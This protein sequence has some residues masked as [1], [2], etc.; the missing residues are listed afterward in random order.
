MLISKT[1]PCFLYFAIHICTIECDPS[2]HSH[3]QSKGQKLHREREEDGSFSPSDYHHY[4]EGKH[5][6]EFDHEAI[7]GNRR[8][9]EE[10]DHLSPK[11]SQTRLSVLVNKMDRDQDGL[12]DKKELT[13]WIQRSFKM[14]TEEEGQ[15]RMEEEDKNEDGKV[16]WKEHIAEAFGIDLETEDEEFSDHLGTI[17]EN[18]MIKEDRMLFKAADL[19]GDGVLDKTEF[20]AFA[21]PEEFKHMHQT[22][23]KH[24]MEK[25]DTSKDG[26]LSLEEYLNDGS[27]NP[28]SVGSEN[29][30]VEKDRFENEFDVNRDGK[31]DRA[32]VLKW[33]VPDNNKVA[34]NEA[35]HLIEE[36]DDNKD[37]KLSVQEILDHHESFVGSE[38]TDFGEHLYNTHKFD[39]EL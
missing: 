3:I 14:L 13:Q 30:F 26:Y 39:D 33:L 38:A 18:Q 11:E 31:L 23:Y 36:S 25:R 8:D 7:I 12:V 1:V 22:L 35:D 32:E 27:N 10:Y 34:E 28:P 29:Y 15:E 6:S 9:A 20:T 5:Q 2:P 17:E 19:N 4:K 24:T 16:T 37:G 21:I